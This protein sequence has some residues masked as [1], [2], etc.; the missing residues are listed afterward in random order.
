MGRGSAREGEPARPSSKRLFLSY[1]TVT[2]RW[3]WILRE[4]ESLSLEPFEALNSFMPGDRLQRD[5]WK[6]SGE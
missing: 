4:E 3:R 2:L 5:C 6:E 1:L